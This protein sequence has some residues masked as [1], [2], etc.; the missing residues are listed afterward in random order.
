VIALLAVILGTLA[1]IVGLTTACLNY[2]R[3]NKHTV[4]EIHVAVNGRLS[5]ALDRI[6]ELERE[7]DERN[8]GSAH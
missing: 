2:V 4:Q 7:L 8:A 3:E 1:A 5:A 6:A